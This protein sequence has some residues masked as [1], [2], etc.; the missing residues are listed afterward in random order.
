VPLGFE[1][2]DSFSVIL[3]NAPSKT[4]AQVSSLKHGEVGVLTAKPD[5]QPLAIELRQ[6]SEDNTVA[7][8]RK[9][10]G[11]TIGMADGTQEGF[12]VSELPSTQEVSGSWELRFQKNWGAPNRS[13]S[14]EIDFLH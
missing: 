8:V 6:D 1:R 14:I 2:Y 4:S 3:H 11:N 10:G 5:G 9:P 12:E 7:T 13:A